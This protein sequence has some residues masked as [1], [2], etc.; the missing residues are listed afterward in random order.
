M[1]L[2]TASGESVHDILVPSAV[3]RLREFL[4]RQPADKVFTRARL[5]ELS[6]VGRCSVEKF[7]KH[8]LLAAHRAQRLRSEGVWWGSER[9]IKQFKKE[10]CHE[11]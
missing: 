11:P 6:G 9:A 4:Q 10:F 1:K 5:V 8:P 7:A 3:R 2:E